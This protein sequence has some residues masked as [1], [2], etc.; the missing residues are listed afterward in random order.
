MAY[1]KKASGFPLGY[2]AEIVAVERNSP[3]DC[4]TAAR[5]KRVP[6]AGPVFD[7]AP[8]PDL[9]SIDLDELVKLLYEGPHFI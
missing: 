9:E 3:E 4:Y 7:P 6:F 2:Y 1:G 8:L 5:V